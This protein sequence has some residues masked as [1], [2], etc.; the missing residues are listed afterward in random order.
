LLTC[1]RT[2]GQPPL[3]A[4]IIG[5]NNYDGLKQHQLRGAVPDADAVEDYL[6]NELKVP[7]DHIRSLR[8]GQAS[9]SEII[10]AFK[11]LQHDQR[12]NEGDPIL[13]YY[14]GH[15]TEVA[16][17]EGWETG[18]RGKIEA[19]VPQDYNNVQGQEVHVIPDRT[20]GAYLDRIAEKHGD[21]IVS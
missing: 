14:A 6:K 16:A 8:D 12:I 13:I 18:G 9:R 20:I 2:S 3:Y 21:N 5:I 10:G 19:L 1:R 17:P 11:G 4:L 15:G 7:S